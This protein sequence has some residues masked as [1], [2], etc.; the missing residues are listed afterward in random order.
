MNGT[1]DTAIFLIV[2]IPALV[3][4]PLVLWFGRFMERRR[5]KRRMDGVLGYKASRWV[6]TKEPPVPFTIM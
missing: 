2:A 5:W 3:L 6:D 1:A 4:I